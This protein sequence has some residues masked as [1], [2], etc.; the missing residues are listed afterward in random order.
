MRIAV[1]TFHRA[2]NCGAALQAWAL[3]TTLERLGHRV[4]FPDC[5]T[6]GH[7]KRFIN[8]KQVRWWKPDAS[9]LYTR[10]FNLL[11]LGITDCIRMRY[12]RFL[13]HL[14]CVSCA[15]KDFAARYDLILIGSDQVWNEI[16]SQP[17]TPLFLGAGIPEKLPLIAYAAS[18]GD[19][20]PSEGYARQL[21][22]A[23]PRFT[24]VSLRENSGAQ[25]LKRLCHRDFPVVADPTLLLTARDYAPVTAPL[26]SRKPFL[27]SYSVTSTLESERAVRAVARHLKL[28]FRIARPYAESWLMQKRRMAFPVDPARLLAFSAQATCLI[29]ASFHGMIFAIHY[30]KPFVLMRPHTDDSESRPA[31]LLRELGMSERLVTPE[32]PTDEIVSRLLAPYPDDI[33][34]RLA[35]LSAHATAWLRE[36]LSAAE[37]CSCR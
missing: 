20:D 21:Q 15:P 17:D 28:P 18:M 9:R 10:C 25:R 5:N 31:A 32:L 3:K 2:Y 7:W 1:L 16:V 26:R 22:E 8:R 13:K 12:A 4:E 33:D 24:A 35:A 34:A 37:D 14:P 27:F 36:A 30:R 11:S 23:L 29:P 6:V 19:W